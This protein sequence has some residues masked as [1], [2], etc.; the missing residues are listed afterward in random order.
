MLSLL[1]AQ[2]TETVSSEAGSAAVIG[3]PTTAD[4]VSG[5]IILLVVLAVFVLPFLI[6]AALGKLLKLPDL[7]FKMGVVLFAAAMGS[8]PFIWAATNGENLKDTINL[9]ID[10]AGGTNLVYR[11]VET[12]D[13]PITDQVMDQMVGAVAK[14][15]NPSGTE[16]VTVRRVGRDRLEVIVPG[17]DQEKVEQTKDRIINSGKLEFGILANNNRHRD[18]IAEARQ[19]SGS[20]RLL[21]RNGELRAEWIDVAIGAD[22]KFK[23]VDDRFGVAP[24]AVNNENKV[25]ELVD[26]PEQ[27]KR[28]FLVVYDDPDRRVTGDYLRSA[29]PTTDQSGRRVVGFSFN[30]KG[31]SRFGTLTSNYRPPGDSFRH[32]LSVI[33]NGKIHSAPSIESVISGSGTISGDFSQAEIK[34][35]IDVL[36]AG[37]LQLDIDKSPV[38]E[39][40]ISPLLGEDTVNKA[41]SA[42]LWGGIITLIFVASYYLVAGLI[43]DLCLVLN[44]ILVMGAMAFIEATFTLPGLAGI[45]LT[46]GM[47]VDANVLI[48]ERIREE[49]TRGS[50]LRMSISNG[51]DRALSTIVDANVTTLITA[52]ILF[53]IG[54]DQVKGFAV[55]LFIGIVTSMFTALYF[56]RLMFDILERKR[57]IK[58]LK[59][60]KIPGVGSTHFDFLSGTKIAV[61]V[62]ILFIGTGLGV[63]FSRGAKM[64]DI[65]FRGGTMVTFELT[66]ESDT[67]TVRKILEAVPEFSSDVSV[68]RLTLADDVGEMGR[69]FRM[70]TTLKDDSSAGEKQAGTSE[71]KSESSNAA[72]TTA[73]SDTPKIDELIVSAFEDADLDIRRITMTHGEVDPLTEE[74]AASFDPLFAGGSLATVTIENDEELGTSTIKRYVTTELEAVAEENGRKYD[75]LDSL[76]EVIGIEGS[77]TNAPPGQPKLFSTM[78]VASASIVDDGD[79]ATALENTKE[80]MATHPVFDERNSF[81]SAVAGEMRETAILAILTSLVAIVAYLWFRFQRVTFGLAAVVALVHDVLAVLGCVAIAA[82]IAG[83]T[84]TTVL[85]LEEFKLNLPMIAAFLTIIGYSL[86]DTI[87]VFDRIREVRGR[88]PDLTAAMINTS[89]NQTLARTLLTSVTTFIV[90]SILYAFGGEGIHGFAFCLVGGVLIGT[91]SSIYVASPALLWLMN[92]TAKKNSSAPAAKPVAQTT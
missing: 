69:R 88:S 53:V 83:S 84:G 13:K 27:G 6:G 31:A 82:A 48:F 54:T 78:R 34:A 56:G 17:A 35:L 59:M 67:A 46:I 51:F 81:D 39:F 30:A 19:M 25:V 60:N 66:S 11:V 3:D 2:A 80:A 23:D 49:L 92:R 33:L 45:V 57:W 89:L 29:Y 28:Q 64:L 10:L 75:E 37:A 44:I 18:L 58:S 73:E 42:I 55:T 74:A 72:E 15:I 8:A 38:S 14:R 22:G 5:W 40:T 7:A 32:R 12:E 76:V 20:E 9:G 71:G 41:L 79:L 62:S 24:R 70:R 16:E 21:Y 68:E 63:L 91:Y 77:G 61:V 85:G 87:V 86:N 36:N 52:V 65:D 26:S 1:F 4:G 47:A 43:A 90:V 50:S